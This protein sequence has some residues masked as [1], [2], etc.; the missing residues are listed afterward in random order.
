LYRDHGKELIF[1][2]EMP[3]RRVMRNAGAAGH[4]S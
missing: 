2:A 3:I 1:I 4:F